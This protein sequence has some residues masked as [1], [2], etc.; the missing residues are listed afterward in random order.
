MLWGHSLGPGGFFNDPNPTYAR[1]GRRP[2]RVR[3]TLP[4]HEL[5]DALT[6]LKTQLQCDDN[7]ATLDLALF[8]NC[9][10]ATLEL[11]FEMH[12]KV[13]H[14]VASQNLIPAAG[15][16]YAEIVESFRQA[17]ADRTAVTAVNALH[18]FYEHHDNRVGKDE[19]PITLFDT[20][21]ADETLLDAVA[22]LVQALEDPEP[23]VS[24]KAATRAA[25]RPYPPCA[26]ASLLDVKTMC[27]NLRS[28]ASPGSQLER[29]VERLERAV[30]R[31]VAVKPRE[32]CYAGVSALYVPA[33]VRLLRFGFVGFPGS[34]YSKLRFAQTGW[35]VLAGEMT[36]TPD[37]ES[38]A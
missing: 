10:L 5:G 21:A 38:E 3:G 14:V 22:G 33:L 34:N 30:G 8:K 20:D 25:L 2:H 7:H 11:A 18:D 27:R 24:A 36:E 28:L 12:G 35:H 37:L 23:V 29:A 19:V 26:D 31:L 13:K 9:A 17:S 16:P 1:H 6:Y 4:L 15:W 32:S